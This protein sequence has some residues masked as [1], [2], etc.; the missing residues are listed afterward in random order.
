[1]FRKQRPIFQEDLPLQHT[2]SLP[3]QMFAGEQNCMGQKARELDW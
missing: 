1:M 2:A 3:F